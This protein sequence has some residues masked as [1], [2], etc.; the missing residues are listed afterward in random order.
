MNVVFH[1]PPSDEARGKLL[2]AVAL[3]SPGIRLE[4]VPGVPALA[5]RLREPMDTIGL[6]VIKATD[7]DHLQ[8]VTDL[9][10]SLRQVRVAIVLPDTHPNTVALAHT[11]HPSLMT[12][13]EN[14][15]LELTAVLRK[16]AEIEARFNGTNLDPSDAAANPPGS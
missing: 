15:L 6:V 8:Q 7:P 1:C 13:G 11:I 2:K 9:R 14:S 16:L 5:A 12:Y 3:A 4:V 10:K